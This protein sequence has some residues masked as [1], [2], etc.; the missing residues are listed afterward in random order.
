MHHRLSVRCQ[1]FHVPASFST[2]GAIIV[3]RATSEWMHE[4]KEYWGAPAAI[5]GL[6]C[7]D[8]I[9]MRCIDRLESMDSSA[10]QRD[11]W[12]R[13]RSATGSA[14]KRAK[15]RKNARNRVGIFQKVCAG[16]VV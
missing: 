10:S 4:I 8:V 9:Q 15:F 14:R 6:V 1:K 16:K 11:W 3:S 13:A 2:D 5:C 7:A 12:F